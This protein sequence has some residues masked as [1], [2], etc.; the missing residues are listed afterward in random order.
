MA[1][2][3]D[4]RWVNL[5]DNRV[6]SKPGIRASVY[7]DYPASDLD[8]IE[9]RWAKSREMAAQRGQTAGL[10]LLEHGHWDWRNKAESV[11][12]GRYMLV[13]VECDGD[14]QGLMAIP[15]IPRRARLCDGILVY[16][17]YLEIAPWNLKGAVDPPRFLGV[18]TVLMAEAVRISVV[19]GFDGRVG[20]HSLPQA[21][22]FYAKCKMTR[23]AED[24]T[25]FDLVYYEYGGQNG[26]NWLTSIGDSL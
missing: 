13:A 1:G 8:D 20:L 26:M 24:P 25:Y 23:L 22:G 14:I 21:E 2:I 7:R 11:E 5:L 10:T 3:T 16:V 19:E 6:A 18:G 4:H 15:R 9:A 17:D 12:A